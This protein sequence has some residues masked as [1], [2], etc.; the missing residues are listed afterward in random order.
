MFGWGEYPLVFCGLMGLLCLAAAI[1]WRREGKERL[2][3]AL[4]A[5]GLATTLLFGVLLLANLIGQLAVAVG[6]SGHR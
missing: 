6:A 2:V 5:A 4:A 1:Q 3:P